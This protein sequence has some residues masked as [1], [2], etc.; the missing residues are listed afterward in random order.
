MADVVFFSSYFERVLFL[1]AIFILFFFFHFIFGGIWL[2]GASGPEPESSILEII[3]NL[4][5][6]FRVALPFGGLEINLH[7]LFLF[8]FL[9]SS[10]V[11]CL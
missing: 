4:M 6:F 8:F 10:L 11:V 9:L 3:S 5:N 2:E 1:R 7:S